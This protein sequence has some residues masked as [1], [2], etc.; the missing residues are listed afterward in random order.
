VLT[1]RGTFQYLQSI[2]AI[3][4]LRIATQHNAAAARGGSTLLVNSFH[5]YAVNPA[6]FA[7]DSDVHVNVAGATAF[8]QWLTSPEA[9]AAVGAYMPGHRGPPFIPDAAPSISVAA[10]KP[11]AG[12]NRL[13][14]TG[15]IRNVAP[16][17]PP[18]SGVRMTLTAAQPGAIPQP[19]VAATT[20]SHGRFTLRFRPSRGARFTVQSP[21]VSKIENPTLRPIFGDLLAPTSRQIHM[22]RSRTSG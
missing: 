4:G 16:G 21:P 22:V 18:L 7:D 5:V 19:V 2:H 13:A 14:V 12:S 8:I 11:L 6:R 15:S 17:T 1:D 3:H 10:P 9:Q 20:D